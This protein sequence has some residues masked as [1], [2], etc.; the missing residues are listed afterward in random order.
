MKPQKIQR[1]AMILGQLQPAHIK[2]KAVLKAFA[3]IPRDSFVPPKRKT[4]AYTDSAIRIAKHRWLFAPVT[5]ATLLAHAQLEADMNVLVLPAASGYTPALCATIGCNV[6]TIENNPRL[7]QTAQLNWKTLELTITMSETSLENGDPTRAPY[8]RIIVEGCLPSAVY[9][10][11]YQQLRDNGKLFACNPNHQLFQ[12]T[13]RQNHIAHAVFAR[14][15]AYFLKD[16]DAPTTKA[17]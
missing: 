10:K 12:A 4:T 7:I 6:T 8:H 14:Q 3:T 2:D 5:M 17:A 1:N 11:L 13:K 15:Q 9:T 16:S